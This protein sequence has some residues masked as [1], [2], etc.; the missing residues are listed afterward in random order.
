MSTE[1]CEVCDLPFHSRREI[2]DHMDLGF[3]LYELE[4]W[5]QGRFNFE[6]SRDSLVKHKYHRF[7]AEVYPF[8]NIRRP[9]PVAAEERKTMLD[10]AFRPEIRQALSKMK[11]TTEDD[12]QV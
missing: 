8:M 4:H 7:L 12:A 1:Q 11:L 10:Y 9:T 2:E 3:E 5:L 6:I